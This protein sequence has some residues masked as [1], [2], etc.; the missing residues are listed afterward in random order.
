MSVT[1]MFNCTHGPKKDC[2]ACL[3]ANLAEV[4][5]SALFVERAHDAHINPDD[6]CWCQDARA[7][8]EMAKSLYVGPAEAALDHGHPHE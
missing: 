2:H 6:P 4:L 1:D 5:K 3:V 8:L 7:V